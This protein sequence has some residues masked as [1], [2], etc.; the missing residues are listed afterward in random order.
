MWSS[1]PLTI[2]MMTYKN[3]WYHT[4]EHVNQLYRTYNKYCDVLKDEFPNL[5]SCDLY[6]VFDY[7]DIVYIPGNE[8]NELFSAEIYKRTDKKWKEEVYNCILSTNINNTVFDT[9]LKK[10]MHD[11]DW[12]GLSEDWATFEKNDKQIINEAVEKGNYPRELV[13]N[14]RRKFI[15]SLKDKPLYVTN[16]FKHR[17]EMVQKNVYRYLREK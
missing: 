10:V 2:E 4:I 15:E 17:N 8:Y 12:F 9:D 16:T 5:N 11:L 13:I 3:D 1:N 6:N 7:H 14:N